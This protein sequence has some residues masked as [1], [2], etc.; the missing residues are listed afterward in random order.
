MSSLIEW[1]DGRIPTKEE[2]QDL[3]EEAARSLLPEITCKLRQAISS[4]NKPK[5]ILEVFNT[6]CDYSQVTKGSDK[7][8]LRNGFLAGVTLSGEVLGNA[9]K[10]MAGM[11]GVDPEKFSKIK[12]ERV[13]KEDKD[14]QEIDFRFE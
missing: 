12:N 7:A 2:I 8:N 14:E 9:F 1:E 3:V 4:A 6:L 11:F 10:G 5:E 13:V